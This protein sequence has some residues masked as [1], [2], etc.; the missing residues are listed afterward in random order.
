MKHQ[1]LIVKFAIITAIS[2][3][4]L[5]NACD[6]DNS[7]EIPDNNTN[8][9]DTQ[10]EDAWVFFNDKPS[11][12]TYMANP[13]LM[14]SQHSLDRR[15]K[16]N[17]SLNSSDVPIEKTYYNKIKNTVGIT[18]LAKSKWLNALHIQGT[19]TNINNLKSNAF[20]SKIEFA[21]KT[22]NT[23][24]RFLSEKS[25]ISTGKRN[26]HPENKFGA[27]SD[28]NYG[29][30]LNQ[31][32]ML[33]TDAL[34]QQ[35]YTGNKMIIAIIDV[36]FPNVNNFSAFE[37]IRTKSKIL[38]GYDFV[39]RSTNFYT[40]SSHGTSVLSIIAGYIDNQ[41]VGTAPDA[42][43]YLFITEDSSKETPLEE[44][45]W[46]E[47]AEKADSLGVDIINTSLGYT[48]FDNPKYD[49]TYAD[50]NGANTIISRGAEIGASKGM[51]LVNANG[52]EGTTSWKYI[53]AP[54]DAVSVLSV[55]AVNASKVI[56]SFSSFG[57]T[58]DGRIKPDVLAQ[59][60]NV[61]VINSAG[62]VATSNGTSFASPV[63]AGA[64]AC[65]WQK[66]STKTSKEIIQMIKQS[67]R[68]YNNPTPQEGY[69]IPK[70]N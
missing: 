20:V 39:N 53:S 66:N 48:T 40:G 27:I 41:F 4:F 11:A 14:L 46:V 51:I 5:L 16:Q 3:F 69:G 58:S 49:Y 35:N 1:S 32:Q 56:A 17:I 64:V 18:V 59:G 33:G 36:G 45:L 6:K 15:T 43:F 37:R 7:L 68:L 28:F 63:M 10:I 26:H 22:L 54:A 9:L 61:Y 30:A 65:F 55:G 2:S 42:S 24:A 60:Q 12:N 13:L 47:A 62:N 57:P 25:R 23:N 67:A 50:M 52:N 44:S 38:G 8:L 29:S 34:H 21:D 70:F 19:K 31:I